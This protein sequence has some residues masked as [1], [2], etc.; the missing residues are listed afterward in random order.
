MTDPNKLTS[1]KQELAKTPDREP[2]AQ[3]SGDFTVAVVRAK[4]PGCAWAKPCKP[5]MAARALTTSSAYCGATGLAKV[6]LVKLLCPGLVAYQSAWLSSPKL[7]RKVPSRTQSTKVD[8]TD[9]HSVEFELP[10]HRKGAMGL[11]QRQRPGLR[12]EFCGV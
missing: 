1:L 8:F 11:M 7:S 6:I 12:P 3:D 9:F 4:T 5:S 2:D 10:C